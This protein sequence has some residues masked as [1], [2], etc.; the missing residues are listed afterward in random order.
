VADF[1]GDRANPDSTT[2][3]G[4]PYGSFLIKGAFLTKRI[5]TQREYFNKLGP[6]AQRWMINQTEPVQL[7][8]AIYTIR[9]SKIKHN[10]EILRDEPL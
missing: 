1:P 6:P 10:T 8:G 9:Y 2:G 4:R 7:S 5:I 3:I